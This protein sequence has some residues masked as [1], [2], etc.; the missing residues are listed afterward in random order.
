[1][2][3]PRPTTSPTHDDETRPVVSLWVAPREMCVFTAE[4]AI[5]VH[6]SNEWDEIVQLL[7]YSS[8][9]ICRVAV[10]ESGTCDIV[11]SIEDGMS[12]ID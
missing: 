7:G 1:M 5:A 12:I 3:E 2:L 4:Y 10:A 8:L 9:Y 6:R 11:I